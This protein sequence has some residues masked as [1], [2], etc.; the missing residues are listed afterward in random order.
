MA[1]L[2][3]AFGPCAPALAGPGRTTPHPK[4]DSGM[5]DE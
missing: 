3:G 2:I 5:S 1:D 4:P